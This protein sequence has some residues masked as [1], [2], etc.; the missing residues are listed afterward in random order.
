MSFFGFDPESVAARTRASDGSHEIPTLAQSLVHGGVGFG[1]VSVV[2]FAVWAFAGRRLSENLGEAGFY[3]VCALVFIGLAG[4]DLRRLVIG[5]DALGRFYGLFAAGFGAYA[6]S[7]CLAWFL[8]R[9]KAGEW[10][11]SLAGSVVLALVFTTA[12]AATGNLLRVGLVLFLA[13]SAGYFLGGFI[14]ASFGGTPGMLLWGAA[15]G[16][17]FGAGLGYTLYHCQEPIR[18][19]LSKPLDSHDVPPSSRRTF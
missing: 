8:V 18:T 9:G 7:W 16:L 3:S 14:Y 4:F 1:F 13:H 10:I 15:Y 19:R 2:V 17:E 5:P 6:V 11:G 12:F